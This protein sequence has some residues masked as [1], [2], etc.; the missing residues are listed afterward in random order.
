MGRDGSYVVKEGE[1]G[2]FNVD[3]M[4]MSNNLETEAYDGCVADNDFVLRV[5]F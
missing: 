1:I 5:D 3:S 2:G 4:L